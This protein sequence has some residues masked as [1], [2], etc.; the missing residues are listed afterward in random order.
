MTEKNNTYKKIIKTAEDMVISRPY[1]TISL[2]MIAKKAGITKPSLY[3]YFKNKEELFLKTF[4]QVASSFNHELDKTQ[5]T[6]L[7]TVEKLR[8]FII[9]YINHFFIKKDLIRVII[10]R[11]SKQNKKLS[12]KLI[13]TREEIIDKLKDIIEE[14][15]KE[16]KNQRQIE[17]RLAAMMVLGMLGTFFVEYYENLPE[18]TKVKPEEIADQI[19]TFINLNNNK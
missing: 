8:L 6:S 9:T 7:P 18:N 4:E 3:Y 16:E 5:D 13:D 17:P 10:Q 2:N 12:K 1:H 11:V 14:V 15:L 19:L